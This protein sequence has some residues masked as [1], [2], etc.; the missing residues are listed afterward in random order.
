[1][2]NKKNLNNTEKS[3]EDEKFGIK[4]NQNELM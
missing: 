2:R 1:M 4:L 3:N